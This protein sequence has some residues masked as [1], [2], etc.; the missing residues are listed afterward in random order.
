MRK[1][2]AFSPFSKFSEIFS[3]KSIENIDNILC[4]LDHWCSGLT[5]LP[6][7]EKTTSS[8]LVWSAKYVW[9]GSSVGSSKGLKILVS[10]VRARLG[11]PFE[12]IG[13]V[14]MPSLF[15][16]YIVFYHLFICIIKPIKQAERK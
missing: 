11:P 5:C 3:C 15:S 13:L 10:P 14:E 1:R 16:L 4:V 7:T 6:V 8:N 2:A 9:P 12:R